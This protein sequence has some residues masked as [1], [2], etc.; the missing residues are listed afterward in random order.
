MESLNVLYRTLVGQT[1]SYVGSSAGLELTYTARMAVLL[2]KKGQEKS[3]DL[4][5]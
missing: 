1:L 3:P 2:N 5:G 4:S